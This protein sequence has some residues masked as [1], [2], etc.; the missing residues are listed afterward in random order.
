[1][2]TAPVRSSHLT[3]WTL[4]V[5]A[6]VLLYFLSVPPVVYYAA[7]N[8]SRATPATE[9]RADL[10]Q[11]CAIRYAAPYVWIKGRKLLD[12]LP[13]PYARWW[14]ERVL[15]GIPSVDEAP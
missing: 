14:Y 13:D 10:F 1:M 6:L 2:S 15:G 12:R 9:R 3:T 4:G 8:V 7:R 5:L 11:G